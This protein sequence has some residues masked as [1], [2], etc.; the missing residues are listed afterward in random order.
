MSA[1][2]TITKTKL[3]EIFRKFG[4]YLILLLM[5]VVSSLL[6]SK[7]LTPANI[8]NIMRQIVVIMLIAC[9]EQLVITGGDIDLSPGSVVALAGCIGTSV[10][11]TT[12]SVL[13]AIFASILIGGLC[14][15]F[16]GFVLTRYGIPAFIVTLAVQTSARGLALVFTNGVPIS[17]LDRL[18]VLGQGYIGLIPIP[19]IILAIVL[20][21]TWFIMSR[22][23]LGRYIYAI[24]G[25]ESAAIASGINVKK[26]KMLSYLTNGCFVGLAGIIL[27]ARVNSGQPAIGVGYE[28]DGITACVVGG[29]SL[30]GGSGSIIG[31][32]AGGLIVGIINNMLNLQNV[33]AYYQQ[34]V[35]GLVILIAVI[36]D[37]KSKKS[38]SKSF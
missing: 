22:R 20:F 31:T 17:N 12:N 33:S 11:V 38:T 4:I 15:L 21:I 1:A 35:K 8:T 19:V 9:G 36:I 7:F 3:T 24:G 28:F 29:I 6:N 37:V 30:S 34:I 13:L 23:P 5:I 16:S 26:V 27:M 2:S 18:T 32:I 25:N 10:F 14:G